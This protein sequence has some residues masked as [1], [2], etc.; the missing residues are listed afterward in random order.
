MQKNLII[1]L[2]TGQLVAL[3]PLWDW[4][5][6]LTFLTGSIC[7]TIVAMIAITWLEDTIKRALTSA[8]VKGLN[9]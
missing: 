6:K 2:V 4:G 1:S 5:D 9:N 7:I 3:L 8:N